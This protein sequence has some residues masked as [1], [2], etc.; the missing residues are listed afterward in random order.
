[1]C[2]LWYWSL[3]T[4]N[5]LCVN[6]KHG[7]CTLSGETGFQAHCCCKSSSVNTLRVAQTAI[8]TRAVFRDKNKQ[9]LCRS[10]SLNAVCSP[11]SCDGMPGLWHNPGC[12]RA[13]MH[14]FICACVSTPHWCWQH[15]WEADIIHRSVLTCPHLTKRPS[16]FY[17]PWG[18][19]G[20]LQDKDNLRHRKA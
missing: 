20:F 12:T 6:H 16:F 5:S 10:N 11:L 18:K 8:G 13:A 2:W 9:V 4:P 7:T 14:V 15:R 19:I 1:M 3:S 17:S